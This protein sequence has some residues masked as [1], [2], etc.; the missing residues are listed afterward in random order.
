MLSRKA[1]KMVFSNTD[2]GY[3]V[4]ADKNGDVY[5]LDIS[6]PNSKPKLILGHLSMLLD[7]CLTE[8]DR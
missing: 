4:V 1:S 5:S 8:D 3:L 2:S 7:I 6:Q